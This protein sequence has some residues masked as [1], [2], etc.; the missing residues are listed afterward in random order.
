MKTAIVYDRINKWGGAERALLALH[1]IFP[2]AD[3]VTAVYSPKKAPWAK[4]FPK[5]VTTFL[6]KLPFTSTNHEFLG[7]FTPIAFEALDLRGYDLVISVTSE[8][9][10]GVITKPGAVHICYCLTPTRYLWSAH[11][12]YFKNPPRKLARIPLFWYLSRPLVKYLRMWD[13][14][15][16][17]RPDY[18]IAISKAVKERIKRYY[19]RTAS[20]IFPP[21]N[22]ERFMTDEHK[23]R[24]NYYLLVSR[25][26]GYKRADLAVEAFNELGLPLV[27]VGVGNEKRGL[28]KIARKNIKFVGELTDKKLAEYYR[29]AK[30]FVFP[31]IE[32]FGIVAVEAQAAGAPV[33]AFR[34]GGALDTV[35]EGRTG[36]FFDKQN[37]KS[38]IEA[39]K[40]LDKMKF[41]RK[42]LLRNA[43]RFSKQNFQQKFTAFVSGVLAVRMD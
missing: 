27:I 41:N 36:V 34:D 4:A 5:V 31:Q 22:L 25:L 1:E 19:G 30:A 23:K 33:V 39:I 8:A 2:Q 28:E 13:K 42:D 14:V 18:L 37:K 26:E 35:I 9:A 29:N 10:K 17:Q 32:D 15:A 12:F 38:L 24:G 11:D 6:Q 7:T 20:V 43:K 16:A 3:L 40:R 21:V